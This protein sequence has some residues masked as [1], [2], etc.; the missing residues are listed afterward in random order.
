MYYVALTRNHPAIIDCLEFIFENWRINGNEGNNQESIQLPN[1]FRT[2]TPNGKKDAFKVTASQSK[3][4]KQKAKRTISSQKMA[5]WLSKINK[6][7][8]DIHARHTM[9]YRVN[10]SRSTALE[11]SVK[12]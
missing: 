6:N 3:H 2:K 12:I 9:T 11:R 1:T 8:Q 7:H 4:Y 10:H 5:K